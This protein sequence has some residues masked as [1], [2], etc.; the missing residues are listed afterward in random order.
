VDAVFVHWE[1]IV[2]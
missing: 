1:E 2:G